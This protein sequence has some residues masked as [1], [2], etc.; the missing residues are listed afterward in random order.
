MTDHTS[1][2]EATPATPAEIADLA[3]HGLSLADLDT[4]FNTGNLALGREEC[5]LREMVDAMNAIY[6]GSVG[7][8]YMHIVDT[9]EKRWLQQRMEGMRG[10]PN[11]SVETRKQLLQQLTAAEGLE[12][13]LG[14]KYAGAKRFGLEGGEAMIPMVTECIQR[15]GEFRDPAFGKHPEQHLRRSTRIDQR[16][17]DIKDRALAAR[18]EGLAH[19]CDMFKCRMVI[20]R[21]KE[22]ETQLRQSSPQF[23]RRRSQID[24]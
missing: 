3:Q 9:T 24:A 16:P 23:L 22:N 1:G 5:T 17:E 10:N 11:F 15:A 18:G 6:C 20:R 21:E 8:E 12:K 7:V 14:T 19:G 13:Y 2:M 4:V